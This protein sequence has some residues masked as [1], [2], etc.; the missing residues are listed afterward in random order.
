MSYKI[1]DWALMNH[2]NNDSQIDVPLP[3]SVNPSSGVMNAP[4][5]L[6]PD[7]LPD[8]WLLDTEGLLSE[9]ARIRD[10]PDAERR[11]RG[12]SQA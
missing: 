9:L 5:R 2:T 6:S 8:P 12:A 10:I 3:A 1:A 11:A 4:Q 7:Q